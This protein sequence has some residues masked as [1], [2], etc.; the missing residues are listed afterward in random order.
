MSSTPPS[1]LCLPHQQSQTDMID[2]V[3]RLIYVPP[4]IIV[5]R[6]SSNPDAQMSLAFGR[7]NI[8][9][10]TYKE[11]MKF[12]SHAF[13]IKKDEIDYEWNGEKEQYQATCTAIS[14]M[15][16]TF[17]RGTGKDQVTLHPSAWPEVLENVETLSFVFYKEINH[18]RS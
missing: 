3:P 4:Q 10:M 6:K 12:F 8:S 14:D 13:A 15:S 1:I 18:F 16:A 5:E 11:A 2:R 7:K 9:H 17:Y